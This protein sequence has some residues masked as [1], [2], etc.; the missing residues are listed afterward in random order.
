[1][2][3]HEIRAY[4][5]EDARREADFCKGKGI[6]RGKETLQK[7]LEEEKIKVEQLL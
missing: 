3:E 4:E 6:N 2:S 1:M 5:A 7:Q